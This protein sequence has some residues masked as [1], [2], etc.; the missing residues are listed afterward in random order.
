MP[1][2]GMPVAEQ[3]HDFEQQQEA[4]SL[5]MW[6]FLGTEIMLFGGVFL[7]LIVYR[8]LHPAGMK[9]AARH[10]HMLLGGANT[11]VLLTS[12]LTM[13]MAVV[14][15]R[16]GL[17]TA[18]LRALSATVVLGI[19][20]LVIKGVEYGMECHDGIVP[21]MNVPSSLQPSATLILNLYFVSTGLH[22]LH[23][24]IGIA[25]VSGLAL[26]VLAHRLPLPQR[27][28]TVEVAGLYWHLVDVIWI[29]LYPALYLIGR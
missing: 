28:M 2:G 9:E 20:F 22:A 3:F 1:S 13:A 23:L 11:A 12:S 10:L 21:G 25:I 5:G 14:A 19:V 26:R 17:R 16:R 8:L 4:D 29:F 7:I 27:R 24:L 18:V 6:L 15:A